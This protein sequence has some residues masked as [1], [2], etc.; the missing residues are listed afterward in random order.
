MGIFD[1]RLF[2]I[3]NNKGFRE[4]I[5]TFLMSQIASSKV[6]NTKTIDNFSMCRNAKKSHLF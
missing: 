3:Y 5:K 1:W 2:W 6:I 4:Q